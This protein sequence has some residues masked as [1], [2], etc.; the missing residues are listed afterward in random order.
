MLR[1]GHGGEDQA[2]EAEDEQVQARSRLG[3]QTGA[4]L[5]QGTAHSRGA[6]PPTAA[7]NIYLRCAV[8]TVAGHMAQ[9]CE[10]SCVYPRAHFNNMLCKYADHANKNIPEQKTLQ[11]TS[12]NEN[13][14][15]A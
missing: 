11:T 6:P 13:K 4:G 7:A 9:L 8:C 2:G 1:S 5:P 12:P 10:Q 15:P 3:L 14:D